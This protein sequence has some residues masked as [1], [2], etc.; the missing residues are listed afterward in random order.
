ME[1]TMKNISRQIT[2]TASKMNS[3][4]VKLVL[5]IVSISL[6]VLGAGAP[7]GSGGIGG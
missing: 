4:T 6:F 5:L 1:T 2:V 7:A 3:D